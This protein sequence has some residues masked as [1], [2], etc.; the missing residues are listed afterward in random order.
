MKYLPMD[1]EQQS[2]NLTSKKECN[3]KNS[4]I[5][6]APFKRWYNTNGGSLSLTVRHSVNKTPKAFQWFLSIL[7]FLPVQVL[8]ARKLENLGF[9]TR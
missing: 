7:V 4:R 2:I 3:F 8:C 6:P 1:V 5:S 9:S